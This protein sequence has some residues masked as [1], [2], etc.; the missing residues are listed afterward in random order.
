MIARVEIRSR[1]D[2]EDRAASVRM[3]RE[4]IHALDPQSAMN[5]AIHA[6]EEHTD[7]T[8]EVLEFLSKLA[9]RR[10]HELARLGR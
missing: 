3:V 2:F 6:L 8:S 7:M 9:G 4:G 1:K 10:A 5:A